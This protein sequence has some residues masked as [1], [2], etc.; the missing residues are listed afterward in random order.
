MIFFKSKD[1][2][3]VIKKIFENYTN[4]CF[5]GYSNWVKSIIYFKTRNII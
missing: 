5:K 2:V 1:I 4:N 3:L